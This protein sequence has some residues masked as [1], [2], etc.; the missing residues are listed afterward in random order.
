MLEKI[1]AIVADELGS[2]LDKVTPDLKFSQSGIDSLEFVVLVQAMED[3]FWKIP[4]ARWA[5]IDSPQDIE[6]ELEAAKP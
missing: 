5:H 2:P 1:L 6:R 4:D 3:A